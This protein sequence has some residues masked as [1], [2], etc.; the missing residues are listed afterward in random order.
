MLSDRHTG[1]RHCQLLAENSVYH[2]RFS[3]TSDTGQQDVGFRQI[4]G[5]LPKRLFEL[6]KKRSGIIYDEPLDS[7]GLS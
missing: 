7:L 2:R 1:P 6:V 4:S 5:N 3:S